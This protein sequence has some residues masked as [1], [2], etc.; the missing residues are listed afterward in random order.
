MGRA[1]GASGRGGCVGLLLELRDQSLGGRILG[2]VSQSFCLSFAHD[3]A[4]GLR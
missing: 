2:N 4:K 3:V 1:L